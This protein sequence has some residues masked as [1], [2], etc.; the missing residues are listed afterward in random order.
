MYS[1]TAIAGFAGLIAVF[2]YFKIKK[3]RRFQTAAW[4][5]QNYPGNLKWIFF[6]LAGSFA[7]MAATGFLFSLFG[8]I[9]L[10]G[11]PLALHAAAGGLFAAAVTA[12]AFLRIKDYH[13]AGFNEK[14]CFSSKKSRRTIAYWI[15]LLAAFLLMATALIM[16]LPFVH[17]SFIRTAFFIHRWSALAA[18]AAA[19]MWAEA[20]L[21]PEQKNHDQP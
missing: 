12:G 14:A 9:R 17:F 1:A 6:M 5:K 16:I 10:Q 2:I 19:F 8:L 13:P 7:F 20:A 15:F 11:I 21:L 4:L 3:Q 18:A